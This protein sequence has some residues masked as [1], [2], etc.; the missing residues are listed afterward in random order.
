MF[1]PSNN[2]RDF[3]DIWS[4]GGGARLTELLSSSL[5]T[6]LLLKPSK[7]TYFAS[8][9]ITDFVLFNNQFRAYST[10]FPA[11]AD[12]ARI[13]LSRY[14]GQ[15]SQVSEIRIMTTNSKLSRQFLELDSLKRQNVS[16]RIVPDLTHEKGI[17]AQS[18]YVEGSM[19]LTHRGA[20]VNGEKVTYCV[21]S[22]QV[23]ADKI[24][25]AY[26][27]FDRRWDNLL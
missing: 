25:R 18:F 11:L 1:D 3:R 6:L 16:F 8:P 10:L 19:N 15:L 7:P 13:T 24:A 9:W 21:A 4:Y 23:G 20:R 14:I 26:L 27:E 2:T 17:L 12:E 22:T 5:A